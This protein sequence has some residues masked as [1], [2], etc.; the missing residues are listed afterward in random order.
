M[1][2]VRDIAASAGVSPATVSRALN[3]SGVVRPEVR[4][5][6][7]RE[8]DQLGYR[9]SR[10]RPVER[11][12]RV[13][14]IGMLCLDESTMG[15]FHGYD[16]VIWGAVAR[17]AHALKFQ[18]V[19][20]DPQMRRQDETYSAFAQRTGVDGF[21]VRVDALSRRA[22]SEIAADGVPHVVVSDRF[23][24]PSVNFIQCD[25]R[26][27]SA[28]AIQHLLD[29]GHRRIGLCHNPVSDTDH[30]DRIAAYEGVLRNAGIEPADDLR[31]AAPP[32]LEG[33]AAALSR[34][35]AMA[36]PPTAIF[37]AD[38]MLAVGV[39]RRA[40][41]IGL[42]VPSEL[43]V[44]GADDGDLRRFTVPAFSA[45]CQ[46]ANELGHQAGNWLCRALTDP[47][48]RGE[49]VR[50]SVEAIFEVSQSTAPPPASPVRIT[51]TGQRLPN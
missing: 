7:M 5:R 35:L 48:M 18:V 23:D 1:S 37:A 12:N 21:V 28:R 39:I 22:C 45:V 51:P 14:S 29:L 15:P 20:V 41:E 42:D 34:F 38:P 49:S 50:R 27:A 25:S 4:Q 47:A 3:N 2:T 36:D 31:I 6:I 32:S 40:S 33:G 16:S 10:R 26:D 13:R 30:N 19:A 43:S 24:D 8:A 11:E 17:A 44:V 46:D 9:R